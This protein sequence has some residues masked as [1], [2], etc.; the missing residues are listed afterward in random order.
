MSETNDVND[1]IKHF[2][3]L[4]ARTLRFGC[5]AP[6]SAQT[7]GDGSRALFLRSD[8]PEDL[9]T[10]LW[11]SWFDE[12]GEHHETKLADPR[13]LLGA[14]ADSEDVPAEEKAR[15][16]RA[17]EGGTGIVG[18]SSDDDGNRIVFTI[19]GRLFLT[20]ID[21][22]DE[23]GAPEP[24]T[25]KLA[26]EWLDEDPAMY[27]PVLNPRIAPDGEH[28]L[29]TTGS[30]LMLVDIGGELGDRITAVYGVSVED[31]DGNPAENTWK[32]GLA[33]FVAG[34]EMDRYDGFWWA[35][36]SQH[37]LF[38]SFDTADEPTWY[39]SDPADP[40]KPAAGRRYPRAL[41]CNADVYLT[42]ITLAFDE[43][44]RYAGITGNA[45]VDWDREA[46][47]YVAAV[48]WRRGHDPL[49]LVQN[50]RQTRDQVLEVAVAADGAALGA[51]R[52]LEEHANDQWIDLIHGT[53][54]YTPDGR[55]VCPLNDMAAD[56][57]RLT[58]DGRP[59]TPAGWNVRAVLDVTDDDVLAVVQRAPEIATEVPDAWAGSGAASDAESLFGGHDARSF[60]VVSI[61]YNGTI[62]PVTTDPGQWTASRGERGIVVSGRDMRS[63]R[64]QMR[65]ILGEQSATISSTAAE[66]GFAPNVTFTRLGEHQ[67]Y[68]AIIA[69]SPSSPYAHSD[70]LPV[71]MKPYGG[72]GFQQVV[73]SQSFYW[74]GQ[75]WAD[76]GFLVVTADG[77]GTTGRGPAW[78]REIFEN[79]K[80][81]TL[82]DQIEAVNALPE[83][84]SRLNADGRRP[85]VPAPDLDK[86]CMIGWS[87]GG[88]LSALAVLDAP[89]VFKAACAGAPPT[90]WTL[91][92]TH[93]TERYLGLDPDVYRRNGIVQDA[94]GLV[95]PLMLIHGF[96]D[97]NVTIAHSLRLS[98]ALMAAGR[99]HTFLPLTGITHMTNDETVAENL[100]TL[101]RD[102][103]RDALA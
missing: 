102:F 36:D 100:L 81:V 25:R 97:D 93:Y 34:E 4:R 61:D 9:V 83:A 14:T 52:V 10:A 17:R 21:W 8:G 58:V 101:Q 24:H 85:G 40:E 67:L 69:P 42:V 38:E 51:T 50:R 84:V 55:L 23:T 91:Y 57:N 86:V 72:P 103:L 20:D 53:P 1:A 3:R 44:D 95:R 82:A 28:V 54:A 2:P 76:Q 45:D 29:Y 30:Y 80:G 78:D 16:E 68:T 33:E 7:V 71:L 99:P 26:G 63:A 35:P 5:G 12:S 46:Y 22:N 90:D 19:N 87:Y 77:R 94:P 59:F 88:F 75:W 98:Q 6:R 49:V 73:A 65:H 27:T 39:I 62:T 41:T 13:E 56:T 74:E 15:R 47:E 96:A 92:D 31:E 32:I 18:Y 48:H 64:A 60:D 37:V 79:M 70:K 43:N 11:L 89:D 66:P